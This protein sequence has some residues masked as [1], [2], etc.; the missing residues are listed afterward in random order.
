[1]AEQNEY[2]ST[3]VPDDAQVFVGGKKEQTEFA[4]ID[5]TEVYQVLIEKV[6]LRDNMFYKP[7]ADT[8]QKMGQKYVLSF[9][10]VI[11]NEGEFIS[12]K[13]WDTASLS[14]APVTRR[15]SGAPTKL[16]SIVT[17]A[18]KVNFDWKECES[19]APSAKALLENVEKEVVGRQLKVAIE[20]VTNPV[21]KKTRSKIINYMP[22]KKDLE[23]PEN[24]NTEV[25]DDRTEVKTE[26]KKEESK[27]DIPF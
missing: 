12:R 10:F 24:T 19:F 25:K 26:N 11:L 23:V 16:F 15:G 14:L 3:N 4:P 2:T 8:P 18:M 5:D 13:L 6:T 20:N 7:D 22:V 1:M 17:K 27:E 21:T 9:Q